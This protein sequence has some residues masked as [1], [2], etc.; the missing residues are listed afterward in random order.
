M[1]TD[2]E[3]IYKEFEAF[4]ERNTKHNG[5]YEEKPTEQQLLTVALMQVSEELAKLRK[6]IENHGNNC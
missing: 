3:K 2:F 6:E 1:I 5:L 4:R